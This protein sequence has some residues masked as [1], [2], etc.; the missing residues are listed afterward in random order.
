MKKWKLNMIETSEKRE[1]CGNG[2]R[3]RESENGVIEEEGNHDLRRSSSK[4]RMVETV[5]LAKTFIFFIF[6]NI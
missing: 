3:T 4:I 1:I 5:E 6:Y 2:R